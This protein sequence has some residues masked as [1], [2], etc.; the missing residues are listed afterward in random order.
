MAQEMLDRPESGARSRQSR[1]WVLTAV[2][3]VALLIAGVAAGWV[4]RGSDEAA[5]PLYY[6]RVGTQAIGGELTERQ[7]EMVDVAAQYVEAWMAEDGEAV[8]SFMTADGYLDMPELGRVERVDDGSLQEWVSTF[9]EI[10]NELNDPM[11]VSGNQV[12]LIGHLESFGD[13]VIVL[14]FTDS[15]PVQ[16]VSDTHVAF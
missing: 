13:W 2:I 6:G 10:P 16:I 14:E 8:A 1:R 11:V 4:L 15:G 12:A 9:G 5:S 3:A 7:A